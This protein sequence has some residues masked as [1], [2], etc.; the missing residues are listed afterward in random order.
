MQVEL[1]KLNEEVRQPVYLPHYMRVH[2]G[3]VIKF[4]LTA[5]PCF[6][7]PFFYVLYRRLVKSRR[8][9]ISCR[10]RVS[11][12]RSKVKHASVSINVRI[13]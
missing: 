2:H 6:V 9:S 7:S 12:S 13:T 1:V 4:A 8:A 11:G 10:A 3:N 5:S